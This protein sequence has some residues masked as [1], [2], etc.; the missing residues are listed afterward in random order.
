MGWLL[1]IPNPWSLATGHLPLV[2]SH[3]QAIMGW[4]LLLLTLPLACVMTTR[5]LVEF[6]KKV[7]LERAKRQIEAEMQRKVEELDA[8]QR[9]A[10]KAFEDSILN[11]VCA[12]RELT[13]QMRQQLLAKTEP[14]KLHH[15]RSFGLESRTEKRLSSTD[16]NSFSL[17]DHPNQLLERPERQIGGSDGRRSSAAG[18]QPKR[19]PSAFRLPPPRRTSQGNSRRESYGG[20]VS[21]LESYL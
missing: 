7:R 5:L 4:M 17:S 2:T 21:P 10:L 9:V 14:P 12:A 1:L 16:S 8:E 11:V 18:D 3:L 13:P 19:V 6:K 20:Q 15:T